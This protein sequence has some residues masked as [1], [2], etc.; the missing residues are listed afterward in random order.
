MIAQVHHLLRMPNVRAA[1]RD[2]GLQVQGLVY[3]IES[4]MARTVDVPDDPDEEAH[5]TKLE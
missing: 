5:S 4:G 2:D 3:D 1:I